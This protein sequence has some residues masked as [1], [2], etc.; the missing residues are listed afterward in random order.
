[1]DRHD[2]KPRR[3]SLL[4]DV[5]SQRPTPGS[6]PARILA[7]MERPT[8][9]LRGR[10]TRSGRAWLIGGAGVAL[11]ALIA[12]WLGGSGTPGDAPV[13]SALAE[14]APSEAVPAA[15]ATI[16]DESAAAPSDNPFEMATATATGGAA[17]L[18]PAP[19]TAPADG[20]ATASDNPFASLDASGAPRARVRAASAPAAADAP[21]PASDGR[22]APTT[23]TTAARKPARADARRSEP[24]LLDTLMG[25]IQQTST[26]ELPV[27]DTRGMDR[28]VREATATSPSASR[29]VPLT[30]AATSAPTPPTATQPAAA[31]TAGV[32]KAAHASA[33]PAISER[34]L[35]N[36]L[37]QCPTVSA[38]AVPCRRSI[39]RQYAPD[40]KRCMRR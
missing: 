35:R 13:A 39:C 9:R 30:P 28:L 33:G 26:R 23:A 31:A 22:T 37:D 4:A 2:A 14:T 38:R 21:R 20:G 12:A 15:T 36:L 6:Q 8:T 32:A 11:L 17:A 24:D 10:G 18:V 34:Q 27:R 16:V 29:A 7:D 40:D 19:A 25:N 3:P 1:M 5:E